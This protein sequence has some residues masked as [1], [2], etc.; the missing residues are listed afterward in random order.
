MSVILTK[1]CVVAA[2]LI[3]AAWPIAY[4]LAMLDPDFPREFEQEQDDERSERRRY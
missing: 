3:L 2:L 4:L 1:A